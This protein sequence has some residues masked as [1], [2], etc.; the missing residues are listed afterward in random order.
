MNGNWLRVSPD[1]LARAAT[2]LDW[3]H[4]LAR[5]AR[6]SGSERWT[7]IDKAWNGLDFLLDRLG[8]EI[9]LV[10]GAE[11]FVELPD[12]EP[13]SEEMFDFLANLEDDWGYGPPS[14]LTPDQVAAA[15]AQLATLTEDDL[16][17]GVDPTEL[18]RAEIYPG[19]WERPGEL[20]W[21]AHYLPDVR[22]FFAA[23][24]KEGDAVI[25]WLD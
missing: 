12:V 15:A 13:D 11:S 7:G 25:C 10:L 6:D 21:V 14:Y 4:R 17:R 24:A 2:D 8:F 22:E 20:E 23:A 18:Y 1:E 19:T 3:A 16:I 5:T 9:P